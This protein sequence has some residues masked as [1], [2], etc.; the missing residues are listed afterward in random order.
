MEASMEDYLW[1]WKLSG[2][3]FLLVIAYW[4]LFVFL[5]SRATRRKKASEDEKKE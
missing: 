5:T 2:L 3:L 1:F 4:A